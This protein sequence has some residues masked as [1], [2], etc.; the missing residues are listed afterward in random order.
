MFNLKMHLQIFEKQ[1]KDIFQCRDFNY[2]A[3]ADKS[4]EWKEDK[5]TKSSKMLM[6]ADA[7]S[8][9]WRR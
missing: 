9:D 3:P 1:L 5:V 2:R 7:K 6:N 4:D 8:R